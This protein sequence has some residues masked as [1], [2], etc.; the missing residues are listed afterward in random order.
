MSALS[1]KPPRR[2]DPMLSPT[3]RTSAVTCPR[4]L[5]PTMGHAHADVEILRGALQGMKGFD[6][7]WITKNRHGNLR[8]DNSAWGSNPDSNGLGYQVPIGYINLFIG[9]PS[10]HE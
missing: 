4:Q 8:V 5:V 7:G 9:R 1:S 6:I 10:E 3:L 2:K